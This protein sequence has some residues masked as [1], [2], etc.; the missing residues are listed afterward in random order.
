MLGAF[1]VASLITVSAPSA[2]E[3]HW[4][5]SREFTN[6]TELIQRA[7]D[8]VWNGGGGTVR[9]A[10]G[11]YPI[12]GLRMRSNTTLYLESGAVLSASRRSGDFR[13]VRK[14]PKGNDGI[15]RIVGERNVAIIGEK[16]SVID[17]NNGY[18][19]DGEEH[20]RGVH[21][22]SVTSVSNL[23]LRGYTI[24][25]TG[26]W[27][28]RLTWVRGLICENLTV[29]A[30]HDGINFH[31]CDN[32]QIRDC[33][34]ET[35]DDSI[36]GCDNNDVDIRRCRFSSACQI[37]RF[38]GHNVLIE[39]CMAKGPCRYVFRGS[40]TPQAKRDGVWDPAL[41]SGRHSTAAFFCYMSVRK[42][43]P[44][45]PPSGIVI[46]NCEVEGCAR[47][48][49]YNFTNEPWQEEVPLEDIR[50]ENVKARGLW[51]PLAAYGG[52]S[53]RYAP[54]RLELE[55]CNLSFNKPVESL[56]EGGN[57]SNIV[58]TNVSVDG[59]TDEVFR[60]WDGDCHIVGQDVQGVK[61]ETRKCS[62]RF[63]CPVR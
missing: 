59:V 49:R 41:V 38:A 12:R 20:Y 1:L 32:V 14:E 4:W 9:I 35:G 46:R 21:G 26:N 40:L 39:D 3:V 29:L 11:F 36:A 52:D 13:T 42:C 27:A 48:L 63:S 33:R 18:D 6:A 45:R 30:G 37:F 50:F 43:V 62:G 51:L 5:R 16:G 55:S 2:D 24:Q 56:I 10:K 25:H 34:I 17:G 31:H 19:P 61:L 22:I 28:H 60:S 53:S 47:L 58:L 57:M 15:I 44:R 54:A 7:L 23:T 8:D